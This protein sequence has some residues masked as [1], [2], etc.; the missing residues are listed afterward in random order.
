MNKNIIYIITLAFVLQEI[1]ITMVPQSIDFSC[2]LEIE[3][4]N[5]Y[6]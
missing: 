4:G 1:C 5:V 3:V 6:K 2:K